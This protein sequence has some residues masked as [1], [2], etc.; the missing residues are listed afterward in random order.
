MNSRFFHVK[1]SNQRRKNH[2]TSLQNAVGVRLDGDS[3]D[4]HIVGYFQTFSMANADK[5][6][7]ESLLNM[8]PRINETMSTKLSRDFT[9]EEVTK[10]FKQVH[11]TKASNPNGMPPL[12]V[13]CHWHIIG[14]S[15][16]KTLNLG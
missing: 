7:M 14:P 8:E 2:L 13:Q 5:G 1:A 11:P 16:T 10:A 6:P 4:N 12:F 15:M 9:E 3:L